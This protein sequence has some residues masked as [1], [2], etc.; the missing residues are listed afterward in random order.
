MELG[1]N[2][3]AAADVAH[4]WHQLRWSNDQRAVALAEHLNTY[5]RNANVRF[6]ISGELLNLLLPQQPVM[7]EPVS[8]QILGARV[9]GRSQTSAR[10]RV[11]L[12][13]DMRRMRLG[14]EA[15]GEV[16]SDTAATK[17]PA[18]V[19]SQ[20][21]AHFHARKML[22]IDRHGLRVWRSQAEV[23]A[24]NQLTDVETDFDALPFVGM[25]ARAMAKQEHD[26]TSYLASHEIRDRVA[27]KAESRFD[28]QVHAQLRDAEKEFLE[29]IYE[30]LQRLHL[31]PTALDLRT[32]REQL[33]GRYRVASQQQLAAYSPRP[34]VP[35]NSVLN[36]Q[37]HQSTL[38]NVL[39][40]LKLDGRR[41][42]L[43]ALYQEMSKT[44]NQQLKPET[45]DSMPE[46]VTVEFA[47]HDAVR[48]HCDAGR[49]LLVIKIAELAQGRDRKWKNFT[50]Q[51]YY[52]PSYE[53]LDAKLVREGT[54]ELSGERL[55]FRDQVALRGIFTKVLSKNRTFNLV[56]EKF[57]RDPRLKS[58][59]I[60]QFTIDDGWI[61]LSVTQ[62]KGAKGR[63][64][65][66]Q[67]MRK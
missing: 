14:L 57:A 21:T 25:L 36:I 9:F 63:V 59:K 23:D 66:E 26:D 58:L 1:E 33:V 62:P 45:L 49:L 5:Y 52:T 17:G 64:A 22:S 7:D 65:S 18:T 2:S 24:D 4:A 13:P 37:L 10:L 48:V 32:T 20:G 67:G 11:V 56:H 8:D 47:E 31:E 3:R 28:Q 54:I 61:G 19:Y 40:Q 46:D 29:K 51:A 30:P 38:N 50:I 12:L 44:F 39:E 60:D 34:A 41:L 53:T 27:S 55:N 42:G 43:E 15:I 16:D 35:D 6:A